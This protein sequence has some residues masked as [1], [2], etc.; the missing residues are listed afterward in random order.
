MHFLNNRSMDNI[1]DIKVKVLA[2]GIAGRYVHGE[3]L[4]FGLVHL[5]KG[6]TVKI[7]HHPHEQE[8]V[9]FKVV[10]DADLIVNLEEKESGVP[11]DERR[12]GE[13]IDNAFLTE[14]GKALARKVLLNQK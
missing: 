10:Y 14:S 8:T 13:I 5:D 11:R 6:S 2:E 3:N 7:H 12:I 1:N 4:S 9:N